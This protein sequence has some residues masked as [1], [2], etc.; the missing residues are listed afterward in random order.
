MWSII[1][2]KDNI[3]LV[4]VVVVDVVVRSLRSLAGIGLAFD[5]VM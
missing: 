3:T 5:H 4:I 2:G 1:S